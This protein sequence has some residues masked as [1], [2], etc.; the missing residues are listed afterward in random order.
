M[1]QFVKALNKDQECFQHI[2]QTFP[3]LSYEKVKA[4]IFDG[5][6]IRKLINDR[7][8]E[9]TMTVVEKEAWTSFVNVTKQFL[10]NYKSPKYRILTADLLKNFHRLGCDMSIKM[11]FL[12]SHL[13]IFPENLGDVSDEQGER[14]LQDMKEIEERHQGR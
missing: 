9:G 2:R 3:G 8:F 1:K 6:Q 11:H 4:G 7:S 13:D 12:Y 14:F 5:L 10:G